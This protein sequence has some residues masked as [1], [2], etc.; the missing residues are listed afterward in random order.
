M[1]AKYLIFSCISAFI[2]IVSKYLYQKWI[3]HVV[4]TKNTSVQLFSLE[5]RVDVLEKQLKKQNLSLS[6]GVQIPITFKPLQPAN[7]M[8]K[9]SFAQNEVAVDDITES[10]IIL[11]GNIQNHPE[12]TDHQMDLI[13]PT[14]VPTSETSNEIVSVGSIIE[15][16]IINSHIV[17][18]S[19]NIETKTKK[20]K[21][22]K[23]EKSMTSSTEEPKKKAKKNPSVNAKD[24]ANGEKIEEDGIQWICIVGKNG[25]H[26]WKRIETNSANTTFTIDSIQ[27]ESIPVDSMNQ[28]IEVQ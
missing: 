13:I 6:G 17:E 20:S 1:Y 18:E 2:I 8:K 25:G 10:S 12:N 22:E 9:T 7:T 23:K 19:A 11:E 26:S 5:K 16:P 4:Q 28:L 3:Q 15:E 21:K 24:Y 14:E 27:M